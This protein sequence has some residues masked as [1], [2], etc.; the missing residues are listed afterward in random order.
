MPRL[1]TLGPRG[2]QHMI[3]WRAVSPPEQHRSAG[4]RE[5][6]LG[7]EDAVQKARTHP[8]PVAHTP[9][10]TPASALSGWKDSELPSIQ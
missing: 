9:P 7:G 8:L 5:A 6:G 2:S 1:A 10:S 3:Q 4:C